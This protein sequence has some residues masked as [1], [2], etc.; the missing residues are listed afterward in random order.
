MFEATPAYSGFSVDDP[1]AARNFYSETLGIKVSR[2]E[3]Q[4]MPETFWPMR[5]DIAGSNGVMIYAKPDH[6]PATFTVLN[7]PVE[8]VEATVDALTARGVRFER[9]EG[10]IETDAKGI[11]RSMGVTIAWFRDPAGNVLSVVNG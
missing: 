9:Y 2:I 7:F 6:R 8:D 10:D 3:M 11:H 1:D 5:L 4:G